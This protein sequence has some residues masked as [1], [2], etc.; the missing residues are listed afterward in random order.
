VIEKIAIARSKQLHR[1][2]TSTIV[3]GTMRNRDITVFAKL[4]NDA[5]QL[6][7]QAA[8]TLLLSARGYMK[9]VRVAR[10]IADL[11][12]CESI[13]VPHVA[14]ALQYRAQSLSLNV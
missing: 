12:N 8:A 6:L 1:F 13:A 3:N 5:K 9:T 11:E 10:T 2:N 7:D 14:E 4:E